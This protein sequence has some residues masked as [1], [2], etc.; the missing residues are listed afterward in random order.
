MNYGS[1]DLEDFIDARS[2]A[3]VSTSSKLEYLEASKRRRAAASPSSVGAWRRRR[4]VLASAK[5]PTRERAAKTSTTSAV[6]TGSAVAHALSHS[7]LSPSEVILLGSHLTAFNTS[8]CRWL[9]FLAEEF[10]WMIS[11]K[12]ATPCSC[13]FRV[14]L[15]YSYYFKVPILFGPFL[16][17]T[18][19]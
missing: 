15:F 3:A 8:S 11:V 9:V 10:W 12:S 19:L 6:V 4:K 18:I 7:E 13:R 1:S 2:E 5:E 17:G 16:C 14:V